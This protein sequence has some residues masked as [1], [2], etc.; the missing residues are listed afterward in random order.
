[1]E[2]YEAFGKLGDYKDS[3]EHF[4][5]FYFRPTGITLDNRT[6]LFSYDENAQM[7]CATNKQYSTTY[8]Y[9][10][11][12]GCVVSVKKIGKSENDSVFVWKEDGTVEEYK[13][14]IDGVEHYFD[15]YGNCVSIRRA[16]GEYRNCD[17]EIDEVHNVV[18][19]INSLRI[20]GSTSA[21]NYYD[22]YGN[23]IQVLR[24]GRDES[25]FAYSLSYIKDVSV[26]MDMIW[27]NIR[28]M[29][30]QDVWQYY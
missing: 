25:Q 5:D 6:Y 1:M 9:S 23:L 2:A 13:T 15:V 26:D 14:G 3:V 18:K 8:E 12:N 11:T 22:D 16:N 20:S 21:K 10:F 28:I 27:K 19:G 7:C 30:G 29:S 4:S 17:I 24:D